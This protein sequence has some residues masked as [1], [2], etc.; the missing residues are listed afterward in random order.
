MNI[1][2]NDLKWYSGDTTANI[3][4]VEP[5]PTIS[6]CGD[7]EGFKSPFVECPES[8]SI[9]AE[10][11]DIITAS[12]T[13]EPGAMDKLHNHKDMLVW[14]ME[15]D[16]LSLYPNGDTSKD[17]IDMPIS[18][19]CGVPAPMSNSPFASCVLKN[20]GTTTLKAVFFEMKK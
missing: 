12:L 6:P 14:F 3:V 8:Y 7:V 10:D 11:D 13:M 2:L 20:S 4:F 15:G 19:P 5:Y 18:T 17:P 1:I 16:K 9:L